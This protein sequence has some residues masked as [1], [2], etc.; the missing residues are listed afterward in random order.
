MNSL[1]AEFADWEFA[2]GAGGAGIITAFRVSPDG[3]SRHIVASESRDQ[4][5]DRLRE[6]E[7][8]ATVI[9]QLEQQ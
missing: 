8:E 5:W 1:A 7:Q 4:L 9:Q 3:R 2:F 6:I